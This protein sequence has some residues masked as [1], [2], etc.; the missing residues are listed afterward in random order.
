MNITE[1]SC[2]NLFL[3]SNGASEYPWFMPVF[4]I[5][6]PREGGNLLLHIYEWMKEV[7]IFL[8]KSALP[9]TGT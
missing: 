9:D 6:E 3:N 8:S 1:S 4:K 7:A 2:G 5:M